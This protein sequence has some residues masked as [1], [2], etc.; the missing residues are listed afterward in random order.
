MRTASWSF[1]RRLKNDVWYAVVR[2][3]L[4]VFSRLPRRLA[5]AAGVALGSV[6]Y[7]FAPRLRRV[8]HENAARLD[9][10]LARRSFASLGRAALEVVSGLGDPEA[11]LGAVTIADRDRA[12]LDAAVREGRGVVFL[13]AHLGAWE[14][15]AWAI[16]ARGYD[17]SVVARESYD[18]RLTRLVRRLRRDRGVRPILRGGRRGAARILSALRRGGLVGMLVDQDTHVPGVFVPFLGRPAWTPR[19]PAE[20]ALRTGA[21]VL[22]GACVR[23]GAGWRIVVRRLAVTR[24]GADDVVDNTARFTRAIEDLVRAWPAEWVWMHERWR[25]GPQDPGP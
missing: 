16:A 22:A 10:R 23:R 20:I 7:A 3:L 24:R 5:G 15:L 8:A 25:L 14:L 11:L 1:A 12:R 19:G 13:S 9:G 18:P 6:A 2:A 4:G 21:A 17:V